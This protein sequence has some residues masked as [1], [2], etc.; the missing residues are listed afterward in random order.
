[1]SGV[2]HLFVMYSTTQKIELIYYYSN[3]FPSIRQ[4]LNDKESN[5]R[6]GTYFFMYYLEKFFLLFVLLTL[7]IIL[8]TRETTSQFV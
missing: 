4:F 6:C 1:M 3:R 7:A 2:Y 5:P 8:R